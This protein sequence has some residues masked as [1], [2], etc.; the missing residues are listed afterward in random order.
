[1]GKLKSV[2]GG[3]LRRA[4]LERELDAE[5]AFHVEMSAREHERRGRTPSEAR[6][7]ALAELGGVEATKEAAREARA[8]R[9]FEALLQDLRYGVRG[10][11]RSPGYAL[12]AVLALALGIGAN[13]AIFSLVRGVLLRPL[14][15]GAGERLVVL[16][17]PVPKAGPADLGF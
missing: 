7:Q 8:Y 11:R 5:L 12:A 4:K 9:G 2:F 13:T 10:L 16:H 17:Q 14:P 3:F 6:R 15:Y 1:M